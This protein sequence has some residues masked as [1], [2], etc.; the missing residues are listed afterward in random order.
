MDYVTACWS[1]CDVNSFFGSLPVT[2]WMQLIYVDSKDCEPELCDAFSSRRLQPACASTRRSLA[3]RT[4]GCI[5][6]WVQGY[7]SLMTWTLVARETKL[8]GDL[9]CHQ[10]GYNKRSKGEVATISLLQDTCADLLQFCFKVLVCRF[11]RHK[12]ELGKTSLP[13]ACFKLVCQLQV[14]PENSPCPWSRHG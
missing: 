13:E 4:N 14:Q 1:W 11:H 10:L 2:T 5:L 9:E 6:Y 8:P 12:C 3:F 7:A